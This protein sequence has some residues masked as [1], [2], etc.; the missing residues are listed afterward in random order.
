M[1]F[2]S[3]IKDEHLWCISLQKNLSHPCGCPRAVLLP[4][5][6]PLTEGNVGGLLVL[7]LHFVN[8]VRGDGSGAGHLPM[9]FL[10]EQLMP[11]TRAR[12]GT[13]GG[14][15]GLEGRAAAWDSGDSFFC[16]EHSRLQTFLYLKV[17]CGEQVLC[18]PAFILFSLLWANKPE[19]GNHAGK[20]SMLSEYCKINLNL[21]SCSGLYKDL[22]IKTFAKYWLCA[23]AVRPER[24]SA[25]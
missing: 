23:Y 13:G 6:R 22:L 25:K 24:S 16:W 5:A 2:F 17:F 15:A 19:S 20:I 8:A 21:Q 14:W 3:S 11:Q 9:H 12:E 10:W 1:N 18:S 4:G 7:G